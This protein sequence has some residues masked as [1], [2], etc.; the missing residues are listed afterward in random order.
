M[1]RVNDDEE[2]PEEITM[3]CFSM[4]T[5]YD[6]LYD[7]DELK[8]EMNY[9]FSIIDLFSMTNEEKKIS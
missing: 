7:K 3:H 4:V 1:R 6:V 8:K 9:L 2:F 5:A